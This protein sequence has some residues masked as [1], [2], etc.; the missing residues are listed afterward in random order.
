MI[1]I[2]CYTD[3]YQ[4][5]HCTAYTDR[6]HEAMFVSAISLFNT[7]FIFNY[8]VISFLHG[9]KDYSLFRFPVTVV[10]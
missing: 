8:D 10:I 5:K 3:T 4:G 6:M 1:Y 2:Y 7:D 9:N